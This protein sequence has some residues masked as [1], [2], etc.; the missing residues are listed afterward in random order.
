MMTSLVNSDTLLVVDIGTIKT[1]ALLFD[2]I[3]GRYRFITVGSASTTL[4]LP[5]FDA[6]EG[7][8]RA[9][10]HLAEVT[11]RIF[12]GD[13]GNLIT[14]SRPDSS[15]VDAFALTMSAGPPLKVVAVGLVQEV[16]V[17]S[18]RHLAETTYSNVVNTLSLNDR[19]TQEARIDTILQTRPDLIIVAGGMEGGASLSVRKLI[20]AVGLASYLMPKGQRPHILFV[21][22]QPMRTEVE[23]SLGGVGDIYL[24]PNIRPTWESEQ[25]APAQKQITN[26]FRKVRS[27]QITGI[28]ELDN[29]SNGRMI[30][31]SLAFERVI[32][33]LSQIYDPS[34]GVLGIDIG[35]SSTTIATAFTGKSS[36]GV[37]PQFGLG[38]NTPMLLRLSKIEDI[39][40]WLSEDVPAETLLDYTY[41][42]AA[43]PASLPATVEELSIEQALARQAMQ[44]SIKKIARTFPKKM[45]PHGA[46]VLPWFEPILVT[47]SVLTQASTPGQ[48]LL[49]ILDGIQPCGVTTVLL[50]QNNLVSALGAAADPNPVLAVQVLGS[51]TILNLG[52]VIA[53]IGNAKIGTPILRIRITYSDG[54]EVNKEVKFGSLEV[55]P[56]PL[57]EAATLR[58]QP[59]HRFD[60]GMGPGRGGRLQVVGGSL[61]IVIDA[62]GRPLTLYTDPVR[63]REK[64]KKWLG[65]LSS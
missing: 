15:G 53:P 36:L 8:R 18:A 19:R 47:G 40:R 11:G 31:T 22:N 30:P 49:M 42:K 55:I 35:A 62:R 7:V 41:N 23:E 4:G 63:R 17:E 50:D 38:I 46:E 9:L 13:D 60:V 65:T 26:I 37:Y 21:G 10:S 16:S 54:R 64:M 48:T 14:P 56:L 51:N 25:L 3:D 33:F 27:K 5:F 61:G 44:L 58:L 28:R 32:R 29:W 6:G 43:F 12:L 1:R 52:A 20:E 34:K 24:A 57:R 59:L 45:T 39:T 2:V